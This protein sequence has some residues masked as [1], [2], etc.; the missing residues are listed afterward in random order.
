MSLVRTRTG[1]SSDAGRW[2]YYSESMTHG[3]RFLWFASLASL[4]AG[5]GST[6]AS[7]QV[8]LVS[9]PP[10]NTLTLAQATRQIT[11]LTRYWERAFA[12]SRWRDVENTF[13]NHANGVSLV[14]QMIRWQRARIHQLHIVPTFVQHLS[15][16]QYVGTLRFVDDPR[17][18]P[19]YHIYL[20]QFHGTR[21]VVAGS[22]TGLKGSSFTNVR[23][24]ITRSTHFVVYHSPYELQGSDRQ[25]LTYLE[26]ERTQVEREFGVKLPARASYYLYPETSLMA[27]LTGNA[28]GASS[29][30]VGCTDPYTRPPSIHTSVWPTYHEPIHVYQLAFEPPPTRST[31]L[32]A[33]LFIAEGMAVAL[34]DRQADPRLSDYCS[35]IV[36]VP[37]DACARLAVGQTRPADLMTDRGFS[38]SDAGNAYALGG[39]FVKYLMVKYG[40]RPFARF[41]YKL[42]A[43]PSDSL[44]DYNVATNA[45]YHTSMSG[46]LQAWQHKLCADG[47]S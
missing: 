43:Q 13:A 9:S 11:V 29:D 10:N 30:N 27:Q 25:Y 1:L 6:T 40:Y 15:T 23:W 44:T 41:Y 8:E 28:C 26:Q 34:E 12:A 22:T 14:S 38:H 20:Y 16:N 24:T 2:V 39:S 19:A 31:V 42:A 46:L 5:C 35:T 21:P 32:V 18:V 7:Q 47:C 45:I 37:L 17:A 36:Y 4:V 33:P 3:A